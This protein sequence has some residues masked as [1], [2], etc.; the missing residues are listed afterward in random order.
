MM[1]LTAVLATSVTIGFACLASTTA[2]IASPPDDPATDQCSF[3]LSPLKVVQVS[4]TSMVSVTLQPGKCSA[5]ANPSSS[6]VCISIDGDSSAGQ[7][8]SMGIPGPAVL[9][10]PYRAGAT[11]SVRGR[12]CADYFKPPYERC[13][14]FGPSQFTL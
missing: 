10:Y 11:Y 2:A 7:C 8:A 3:V 1:R 4:G 13:Q 14:T 5:E 6:L 9:Y 12:G